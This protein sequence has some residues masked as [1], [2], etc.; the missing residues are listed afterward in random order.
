MHVYV[1]DIDTEIKEEMK[2]K[3]SL[4]SMDLNQMIHN[5]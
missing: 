1:M 4:K 2:K 3:K 5:L